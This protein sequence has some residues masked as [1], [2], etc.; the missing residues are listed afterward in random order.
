M[1]AYV[2]QLVPEEGTYFARLIRF[3][4]GHFPHGGFR[5]RF[6]FEGYRGCLCGKA[7]L[8]TRDHI[9]F[10]CELW[11]RKHKP[12]DLEE[13]GEGGRRRDALDF[14]SPTPPGMDPREHHRLEWHNT[15]PTLEDVAEFL[16]VNPLVGTFQ[17][18]Q[19]VDQSLDDL[20]QGNI[21]SPAQLRVKLHTRMRKA[22]YEQWT[23]LH[24]EETSTDFNRRYA[25][26]ALGCLEARS[27]LNDDEKLQV[28]TEFGVPVVDARRYLKERRQSERECQGQHTRTEPT[29][30]APPG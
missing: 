22:A 16:K 28:L 11:I 29:N 21:N 15:P 13:R 20:E 4:S 17:W 30:Q 2:S 23:Q 8:E 24:P 9:W 25:H 10:D 1:Q 26:A 12:P 27:V 5:E 7:A 18:M 19:L 14:R 6:N 3:T